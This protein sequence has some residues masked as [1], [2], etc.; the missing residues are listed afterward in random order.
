MKS[1]GKRRQ[2]LFA[3][4][5]TLAGEPLLRRLHDAVQRDTEILTDLWH[6]V[7]DVG[8]E[9]DAK[10]ERL[11]DLLRG[12]LRGKKVIVFTYYRDTARYLFLRRILE[13]D[14]A[15]IEEE[16]EWSELASADVL[17]QHLREFLAANGREAVE[18]LPDGIHSGLARKGALGV[19]FYFR[20]E[21]QEGHQHFWRYADLREDQILD[22]RYV[23]ASLIACQPDTSRVVD[24][25]LWGR[26]FELQELVIEDILSSVRKQVSL[27]EAPRVIDPLQQTVA[28]TLQLALTR[29]EVRRE[30]V[31]EAIR[32]LTQPM[33][34]AEVKELRTAFR[35]WRNS[36]ELPAL[37][38]AV[39]AL[40]VRRGGEVCQAPIEDSSR[41][42]L[43]RDQ[44]RLICFD[45]VTGG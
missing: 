33:V 38:E 16:E 22:N 27:E 28:T 26:I 45:V 7:R 29:P 35:S 4:P 36:G 17:A 9:Q 42:E 11:K 44:L 6:R 5:R 20:A 12:E 34:G 23:I 40:R 18:K 21:S 1:G 24:P 2:A 8:P 41:S 15:V 3:D 19:Y 43:D 39:E 25:L 30:Q 37:L 13:E 10:L 14:E 31:V 32:F